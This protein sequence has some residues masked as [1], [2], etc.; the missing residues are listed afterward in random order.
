MT[1]NCN[2]SNTSS[3]PLKYDLKFL[4][5]VRS[6]ENGAYVTTC[7]QCG[8]CAISCATRE[9]MDYSPRNLF[10][11]IKLGKKEEVM[12]CNTM[13]MCT[14]CLTC[15]VR[16]PRG[17]PL[18]DVMHD[19]KMM[20]IQQGY[21]SY[22]Q[23]AFYQAFWEE[24]KTRGRVFEGGIMA[25]YALKRGL[26]EIKKLFAMKDLGMDMLYHGRM[27]LMPPAKIK[28]LKD[29]QKI[30]DKAQSIMRREAK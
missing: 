22:P 11:L 4:Q 14:S 1:E 21:T 17:I 27:P 6:L 10:N 23:A 8:M 2:I 20:A 16:C 30:I 3:Q 13:W 12:N 18:V 25:R 7:M 29:L 15:L 26:G 9:I 5:E 19:F 24:V 28:G